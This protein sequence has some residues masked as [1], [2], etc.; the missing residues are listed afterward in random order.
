MSK[1]QIAYYSDVL[2]IW[3]YAAERR[4][5][6]LVEVFGDQISIDTHYCS[7]FPDAWTKILDKWGAR[8]GFEAFNGHLN[9]VAQ[10][11]PHLEVHERLWLE[12]RPRTSAAA[13]LFLKA[14]ETIERDDQGDRLHDIAYP[15]RLINRAAWAMRHAF[16]ASAKDISDWHVHREIAGDL[17]LDYEAIQEKILSSEAI[18][19]LAADYTLSQTHKVEGSPSFIMNNGRQKLFGNIGYRLLE[20][21]VQE[22]LRNPSDSEASWC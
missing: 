2:C 15:D 4:L 13:H 21:N 11:F 8:G 19:Q 14:V 1:V 6:E 10:Q 16:F 7:V 20:A 22:L 18:A 3:A 17:G 12:T 9:D 5:H